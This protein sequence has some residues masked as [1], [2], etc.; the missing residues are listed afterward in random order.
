VKERK[1][2][3]VRMR[4]CVCAQ[5]L[6]AHLGFSTREKFFLFNFIHDLNGVKVWDEYISSVAVIA[7]EIIA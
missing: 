7:F 1:R 3:T 4:M 6:C 2:I 5:L